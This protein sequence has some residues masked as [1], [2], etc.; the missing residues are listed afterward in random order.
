MNTKYTI[1]DIDNCLADDKWRAHLIDWDKEGNERYAIYNEQMLGDKLH[2]GAEFEFMSRFTTPVFFTGRCEAYKQKTL[3]WIKRHLGL[4]APYMF[5]RANDD[6]STPAALKYKMLMQCQRDVGA[7]NIIAAFDDI[8]AII[9]M[10]R[11]NGIAACLLQINS[12]FSGIYEPRD[13]ASVST[14]A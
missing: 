10:Y 5:M 14:T 7:G 9:D 12:D 13:L 3:M 4:D 1:W 2:H 6:Q 11:A 8:P